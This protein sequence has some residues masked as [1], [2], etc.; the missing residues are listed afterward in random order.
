M[1]LVFC[2]NR[3]PMWNSTIRDLVSSCKQ[4]SIG[5]VPT[6]RVSRKPL[7][8]SIVTNRV[9][10]CKRG[11][12]G[13][14]ACGIALALRCKEHAWMELPIDHFAVDDIGIDHIDIDVSQFFI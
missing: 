14:R 5:R 9:L 7:W 1:A 3:K 10:P 13:R 4:G 6:S 2:G 8:N 11:R 12:G